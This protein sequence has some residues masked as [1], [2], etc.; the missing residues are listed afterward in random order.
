MTE[1]FPRPK[2]AEV[3]EHALDADNEDNTVNS[4][5]PSGVQDYNPTKASL[6]EWQVCNGAWLQAVMQTAMNSSMVPGIPTIDQV[7][8]PTCPD[9]PACISPV[10]M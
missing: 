2:S 9:P 1:L 8:H 7:K 6:Y 3:H 5:F 4:T 10:P